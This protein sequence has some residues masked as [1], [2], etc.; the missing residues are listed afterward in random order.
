[1]TRTSRPLAAV[2]TV[3]A[4]AA[5][6]SVQDVLIKAISGDYP[7]HQM[8]TI[9]CLAAMPIVV[10][11][12][13]WNEPIKALRQPRSG[14][15]L[16]RGLVYA[17]ASVCFYVTATAMP[18]PEA[19]ALYFTMPLL[20]AALA[21]PYLGERVP[22]YRWI[23]VAAGFS[24][25]VVMLRPGVGV[26]N[27]AALL[28]LLC[29]L[30]YAIGHLMTRRLGP[31]I[32]TSVLAVYQNAMYLAIAGAIAL[33]F[34]WGGLEIGGHPSLDYISRPWVWPTLEDAL[35]IM[36]I[37]ASTGLLMVLFTLAYRL[38]DSSFVAPFEYSAMFWAVLASY[39]IL[40]ELPDETAFLGIAMVIGAG[41]FMLLMDR[42]TG[43][44]RPSE[45]ARRGTEGPRQLA[46][47]GPV[48]RSIWPKQDT[49]TAADSARPQGRK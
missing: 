1:M 41:L 30:L 34:G 39:A 37:G 28:G 6:T 42:Y 40:G 48:A 5:I 20:V 17:T 27:P 26:F 24:G 49:R 13:L 16:L 33:V 8:Q 22:L 19:V 29:A 36:F 31:G 3:L 38:A 32:S 43:T 15:I 4:A 7:F 10:F 11:A 44:K 23:A 2:A 46:L 18:F 21:G 14:F 45:P 25:I 35:F 12:L 47:P 9:R